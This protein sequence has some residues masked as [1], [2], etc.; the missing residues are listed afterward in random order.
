MRNLAL[1][2]LL[3]WPAL[4]SAQSV[5]VVPR[6]FAAEEGLLS[7]PYP[8]STSSR[9]QQVVN[10]LVGSPRVLTRLSLRRDALD[11]AGWAPA[12]IPVRTVQ[13]DVFAGHGIAV[14]STTTTYATNYIGTPVR[15][16][17]GQISTPSAWQT[18][19]RQA[20]APLDLP[21][22]FTTPFVYN[23]SDNLDLDFQAT[24]TATG[25]VAHDAGD[26]SQ[27]LF[28][29][30]S[31]EMHGVGCATPNGV[32][33]LRANVQTQSF[34][35][36]RVNYNWPL[37]GAPASAPALMLVGAQR[38]VIPVPGLCQ[39]LRIVPLLSF[40][41]VADASGQWA[42]S[43]GVPM[44]TALFSVIVEV[45]AAALDPSQTLPIK[46]AVSNG[47]ACRAAPITV[48]PAFDAVVLYAAS[49]NA[50]VATSR[51]T[52]RCLVMG[53]Q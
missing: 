26:T 47:L 38:Q 20:P 37:R 36:S 25:S 39:P 33:E 32:L 7:L 43:I 21:I 8:L 28:S 30:G 23:G 12:P 11:G 17:S 10:D 42:P 1:L 6:H 44:S 27:P 40:A 15:V 29:R 18:Q 2:V 46:L 14:A 5:V 34:P 45:Q 13:L 50:T 24:T 53:M 49:A 19:V 3:A 51:L 4:A 9:T 22:V 48:S 31:L 52:G 16:F 35:L 41:G